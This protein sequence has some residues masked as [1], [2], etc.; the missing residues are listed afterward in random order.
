MSKKRILW[1]GDSPT[2]FTGFGRVAREVLTRLHATG[3]YDITCLGWYYDGRPYDTTA[4]PFEIFRTGNTEFG[5]DILGSLIDTRKP[6]VMISLAEVWMTQWISQV[7]QRAKTKWIGYFPLDGGPLH[8]AFAPLIRAMDVPV[9]YSKFAQ[10]VVAAGAPDIRTELI[11][12]GV[13]TE[14]FHPMAD[15]VAAKRDEGIGDRFVVG[16]VARNQTRKQIPILIKAF[17]RFAADKDDAFLYLH[18]APQD[19]GWDLPDL[20][21]RYR[22]QYKSHVSGVTP[23]N[24]LTDEGLNRL[25]NCFDVFALPTMGEGF[26]LPI[27]EAMACG[28]PVVVT[29]YSACVE[30]VQGRGEFIKVKDLITF[31]SNNINQALADTDDLVDK[32]ETLYADASLRAAHGRAGREFAETLKWDSLT[33]RWTDLIESQLEGASDAPLVETADSTPSDGA[34]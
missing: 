8:S 1:I 9:C 7:P 19:A 14:T 27:V 34:R 32:L 2:L 17:A 20:L 11:Y 13:D 18:M 28:V 33:P 23:D 30:L 21:R 3:D 16:C 12:H 10:D 31:G 22:L 26:G 25:Y 4:L 24:G 29:E 15:K 6:D 5:Q